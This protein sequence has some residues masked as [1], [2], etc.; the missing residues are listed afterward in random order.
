MSGSTQVPE[1]ILHTNV[2]PPLDLINI[3]FQTFGKQFINFMQSDILLAVRANQI[4]LSFVKKTL[5]HFHQSRY[6]HL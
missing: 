6:A 4:T 2:L 5:A 3:Y 1:N